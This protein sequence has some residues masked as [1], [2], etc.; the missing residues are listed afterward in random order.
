MVFVIIAAIAGFVLVV[1]F[2]IVLPIL[3]MRKKMKPARNPEAEMES[4]KRK[5]EKKAKKKA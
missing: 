2:G 5:K 1:F 4:Q 3:I